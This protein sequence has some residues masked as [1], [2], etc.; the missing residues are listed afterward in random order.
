VTRGRSCFSLKKVAFTTKCQ[1]SQN[2][3]KKFKKL[4]KKALSSFKDFP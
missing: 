3:S 2:S 1:K 4:T